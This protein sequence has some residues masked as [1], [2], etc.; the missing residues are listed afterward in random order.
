MRYAKLFTGDA[1]A[2]QT[3]TDD[4]LIWAGL[5]WDIR[6]RSALVVGLLDI[7]S[8]QALSA[9]PPVTGPASLVAVTAAVAAL[10]PTLRAMDAEAQTETGWSR[11]MP[12]AA[13]IAQTLCAAAWSAFEGSGHGQAWTVASTLQPALKAAFATADVSMLSRLAARAMAWRTGGKSA[14]TNIATFDPRT[15]KSALA[16]VIAPVIAARA[17]FVEAM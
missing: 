8:A 2:A 1:R 17:A 10:R 9:L 3:K 14:V 12:G 16:P 15:I 5:D 7:P 13:I 4:V 6:T 11:Q